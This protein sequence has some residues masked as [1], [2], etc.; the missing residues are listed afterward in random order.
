MPLIG[1]P[2]IGELV[3]IFGVIFLLFGA[4]KLPELGGAIGESIKN[5]KKGVKEPDPNQQLPGNNNA[6]QPNQQEKQENQQ[7]KV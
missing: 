4:K 7:P 3:I 6:N 1:M 2:G 5:F